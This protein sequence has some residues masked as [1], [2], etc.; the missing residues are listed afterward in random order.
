MPTLAE[1]LRGYQPPTTSALADPIK[2]HFRTLPQQIE[3]NQRAMDKTMAGM[4]Q[5]DFLGKPNP[6]YYPEAMGEF[7]QNYMPAVMGSTNAVKTAKALLSAE[8]QA[9]LPV[10]EGGLGLSKG[11]SSA[12]RAAAQGYID[13]YH[14][15]ERLDRLLEGKT[16]DPKRATSGPMPYGTASN[17]MASNY[18]TG[19][20]DTSR[21]ANDI[22]EMANYFQVSP[23][24]LGFTRSR[25]PYS[26]EQTWNFLDPEKKAEILNKAQRVG[27]ENL[28]EYSGKF[29]T[30][31]EGTKGMPV[32]ED[33]WNYY[34][35]R[36]SQGN[37]LTALK[38]IWAE[39]GNLGAYDQSKLADIYKL[40]GYPHEINQA[41]APWAS[42]EGV[43]LGKARITNPIL[44]NNIEEIQNNIIPALKEAFKNDRS[45][46]KSG[47]GADQWDKNIRYTPKEW[48]NTLEQDL[49]NGVGTPI[50][51][52]SYVWTSIPDKVTAELKKLGYNGIIDTGGKMGGQGHQVVIPFDPSQVRSRFAAFNPKDVNKPD[53]LA[54]AMAVPMADEDTR[55]ATLEKLFNEQK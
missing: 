50:P 43:L 13:Y 18:A 34:L 12:E 52:Q 48:V 25:T 7:T 49:I 29:I 6:N 36:E 47:G 44:T 41:N 38:K 15:T 10:S 54:G 21:I 22:G 4:Y 32:S 8:K 30:H 37:P 9:A 26:V 46:P 40:V 35:N 19:K 31:P 28:D 16:L 39:S 20:K 42:A 55:K 2:E 24:D 51:E 1:A 11:N 3:A 14:G 23:K 53:L 17:Q 45:R 33:T 27:F 5:T